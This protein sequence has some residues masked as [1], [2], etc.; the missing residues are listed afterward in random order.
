M[1]CIMECPGREEYGKVIVCAASSGPD[2]GFL[3]GARI[4]VT[5]A[6]GMLGGALVRTLLYLNRTRSLEME[7]CLPV[8]NK[9]RSCQAL[10]GITGRSEA[11]VFEC[12][13]NRPLALIERVD[14]IVHAASPTASNDFVSRPASVM[15]DMLRQHMNLLE[16]A[17][18]KAVR[19][20]VYLS[21]MEV[22]G[23]R[24]GEAA[25]NDL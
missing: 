16:F 19:R 18:E 20:Y 21:S 7:L 25:E 9:A 3:H 6:T 1:S 4:L 5:G 10:E 15:T 23:V 11:Q 8:R 13:L 22:F 14:Y 2:A 12:D 24:Q 17:N